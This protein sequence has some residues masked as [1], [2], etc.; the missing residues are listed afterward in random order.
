MEKAERE[1]EGARG[2]GGEESLKIGSW[3]AM[4]FIAGENEKS[5]ATKQQHALAVACLKVIR[6]FIG[7]YNKCPLPESS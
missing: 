7:L 2:L 6:I 4:V 3:V 1:R 5:T